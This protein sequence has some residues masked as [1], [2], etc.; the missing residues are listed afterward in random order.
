[1]IAESSS[2]LTAIGWTL[3]IKNE[4]TVTCFDVGVSA[5]AIAVVVHGWWIFTGNRDMV[6]PVDFARLDLHMVLLVLSEAAIVL[7]NV[8]VSAGPISKITCIGQG[9]SSDGIASLK[10]RPRV[11]S[12][13]MIAVFVSYFSAK[14]ELVHFISN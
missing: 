10:L 1:V 6:V 4:A 9:V 5:C 14:G 2:E 3:V 11:S 13:V 7:Y 8:S 12:L